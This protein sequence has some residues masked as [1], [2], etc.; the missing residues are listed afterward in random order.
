ML[1]ELGK[2]SVFGR[3]LAMGYFLEA[4]RKALTTPCSQPELAAA[5]A[6]ATDAENFSISVADGAICV[7]VA[8]PR[9]ADNVLMVDDF[10][11]PLAKVGSYSMSHPFMVVRVNGEQLTALAEAEPERV[12]PLLEQVIR[13]LHVFN[14]EL[15]GGRALG[16][17][18]AICQQLASVR[19]HIDDR[20]HIGDRR[21]LDVRQ[22]VVETRQPA[23]LV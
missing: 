9:F 11:I 19:Q 17:I 10:S 23:V 15:R 7:D 6:Q 3:T 13:V 5:L 4:L 1:I 22:R 2:W 18:G 12:D 14:A 20:Q 16:E 21:P 8:V